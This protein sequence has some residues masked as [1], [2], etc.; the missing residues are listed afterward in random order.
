MPCNVPPPLNIVILTLKLRL[1]FVFVRI[2]VISGIQP[3]EPS[4]LTGEVV[5]KGENLLQPSS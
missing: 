5:V 1:M 4:N 2:T 3:C